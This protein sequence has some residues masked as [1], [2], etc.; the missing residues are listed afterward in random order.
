MGGIY[1]SMIVNS[2]IILLF[3]WSMVCSLGSSEEHECR[4]I[5]HKLPPPADISAG[6]TTDK[7]NIYRNVEITYR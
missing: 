5:A 2:L 3:I 4:I 7:D 1:R 6:N